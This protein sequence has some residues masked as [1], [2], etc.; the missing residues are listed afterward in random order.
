MKVT[1][2]TPTES[3]VFELTEVQLEE[4]ATKA[5]FYNIKNTMLAHKDQTPPPTP[6]ANTVE[7]VLLPMPPKKAEPPK[8]PKIEERVKQGKTGYS[9]FIIMECETCGNVRTFY[10]K[11]S[12]EFNYCKECGKATELKVMRKVKAECKCGNKIR[13]KT[14][15]K[16]PIIGIDCFIC[17][18]PIDL[19]FNPRT[20]AYSTMTD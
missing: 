13:Y 16:S 3:A 5:S 19:E 11:E 20:K 2:S 12:I 8:N 4:L 18:A 1:I 14:N 9:G 17:G 15:S 10:T 7:T 6:K